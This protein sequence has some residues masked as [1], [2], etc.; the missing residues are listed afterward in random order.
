MVRLE[1]WQKV[2]TKGQ[3]RQAATME[4]KQSM[5]VY[6]AV[7]TIIEA[8]PAGE[9]GRARL[10][11]RVLDKLDAS[12]GSMTVTMERAEAEALLEHLTATAPLMQGFV[13]RGLLPHIDAWR[14]ALATE[15][16]AKC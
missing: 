16:R 11:S 8:A 2:V 15:G 5:T 9:I 10:L 12:V 13:L 7:Y 6:K 14:A 4:D 1:G 3:D